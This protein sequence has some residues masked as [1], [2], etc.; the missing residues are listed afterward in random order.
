M[1]EQVVRKIK[2]SGDKEI[3][4]FARDRLHIANLVV[5]FLEYQ[6]IRL[7]QLLSRIQPT[8]YE[9]K[10]A[11]PIHPLLIAGILSLNKNS[12][13]MIMETK[14]FRKDANEQ[15]EKLQALL[16]TF[17]DFIKRVNAEEFEQV[18]GETEEEMKS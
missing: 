12:Q 18:F 5:P 3:I 2:F 16:A 17:C 15:Q 8:D 11:E 7:R 10:Q 9:S 4:K 14:S 13:M 1:E 6:T